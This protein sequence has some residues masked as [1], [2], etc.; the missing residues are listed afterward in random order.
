MDWAVIETLCE[1][2]RLIE[3]RPGPLTTQL[4]AFVDDQVMV[5]ESPVC[6]MDGDAEMLTAGLITVTVAFAD[7]DPPT[8]VHV[9]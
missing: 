7:A 6:T 5:L 4:V 9:T 2:F 1:P 8:P 3:Y